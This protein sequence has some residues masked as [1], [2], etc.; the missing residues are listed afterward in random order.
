MLPSVQNLVADTY[1]SRSYQNPLLNQW[2]PGR[3]AGPHDQSMLAVFHTY[4]PQKYGLIKGLLT[5]G[6]PL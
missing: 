1:C 2:R 5:I 4:P 6:F 3:Q